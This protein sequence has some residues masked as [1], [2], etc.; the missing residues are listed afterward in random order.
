MHSSDCFYQTCDQTEQACGGEKF[1][2]VFRNVSHKL[3]NCRL[4]LYQHVKLEYTKPDGS[5]VIIVVANN[6]KCMHALHIWVLLRSLEISHT[7][8]NN[9]NPSCNFVTVR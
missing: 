4:E 7:K 1:V 5:K 3:G 2:E 9:I 6:A 8:Q